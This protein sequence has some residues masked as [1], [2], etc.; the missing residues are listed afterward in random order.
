M[1][2]DLNTIIDIEENKT[3]NNNNNNNNNLADLMMELK[4]NPTNNAKKIRNRNNM[5]E[6]VE[7]ILKFNQLEQEG[8]GLNILTPNRMLSKLTVSSAQ[9]KAGSNSEKLK[10]EIRQIL[11]SLNRLKKLTKNIYKSLPD[12]I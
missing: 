8:S 1:Y 7:L 9:L 10:N 11:Y 5:V 12:M 2:K 4:N 3:K 6:I